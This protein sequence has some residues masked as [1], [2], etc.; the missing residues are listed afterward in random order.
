[1][2]G[3]RAGLDSIARK[4]KRMKAEAPEGYVRKKKG[5]IL[6]LA[7]CCAGVAAYA[8]GD[9][10][11]RKFDA[12]HQG[13]YYALP[14]YLYGTNSA[15]GA[16]LGYQLGKLHFRLDA[17][18]VADAK[19][20]KLVLFTNPSIGAFYSEDWESKIRTYQG[21][22]FGMQKGLLNSF[23]GLSYFLDFLTG[24]EW[25]V[26]ERR[27]VYLE[28]GQGMGILQKV[29]AFKGGTIIGGGIKCF[30]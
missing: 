28:I 6:V 13:L 12:R 20:D 22:S 17:S 5:W 15:A 23:D 21:L 9:N 16:Q 30:F 8:D 27:A 29:G 3:R 4:M 1:M 24:A 11:A 2:E 7:L 10:A 25:F 14:A 19:D 18:V 26:F